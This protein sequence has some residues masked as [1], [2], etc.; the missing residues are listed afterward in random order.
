MLRLISYDVQCKR[1]GSFFE[2]CIQVLQF[3]FKS[4]GIFAS[5]IYA[6]L[7]LSPFLLL[8][9]CVFLLT[10]GALATST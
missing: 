5:D 1:F 6:G 2:N 4:P 9:S 8:S 10:G 7:F 3:V